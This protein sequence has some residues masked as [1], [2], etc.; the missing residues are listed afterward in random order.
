MTAKNRIAFEEVELSWPPINN[1]TV[2]RP[3]ISNEIPIFQ[4]PGIVDFS[5]EENIEY[6]N[7]INH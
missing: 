5:N 2:N 4:S 7:F 1:R 6:P 3:M